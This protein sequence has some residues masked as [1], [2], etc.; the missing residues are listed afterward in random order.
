M[1]P[2]LLLLLSA[3]EEL[4]NVQAEAGLPPSAPS[5]TPQFVCS[6]NNHISRIHGMVERL[7]RQYGT[8]LVDGDDKAAA[9]PQ[10]G[11]AAGG[12]G[13]GSQA[14]ALALYAF[15]TLEQLAAATEEQLRADGFGYR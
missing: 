14:P 15:P 3:A 11:E 5:P 9:A 2:P 7:C 8:P 10:Q 13:G 4:Q 6:S 12:N 1:C